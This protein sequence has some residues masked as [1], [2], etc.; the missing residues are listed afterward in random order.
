MEKLKTKDNTYTFFN[1]EYQ[2]QYHSLSGAVEEAIKKYSEPCKIRSLADKQK[3]IAILDI[4]FGLGYNTASALDIILDVNPSCNI[5]VIALEKDKEILN[6]I[7]KISNPFKSYDLIKKLATQLKIKEQN[8]HLKL[9][10][11]DATQT[12]KTISQ[13][14]DAVFLDPFSPKKNS[15]LWTED[16]F[17]SIK[18]V[19]KKSAIL[20]TYS[21]ARVVRD[22]L[23]K[24]GFTVKDG[25]SIGRKAP[26]TIAFL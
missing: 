10:I 13:K 7:N 9:I 16:F 24:A 2:E 14:F 12:I 25:P 23:I 21:C 17:V 11:G 6:Q 18:K 15:E 26:S 5:T 1:E 3:S 20:A 22:N 4:C 19:M 8:T